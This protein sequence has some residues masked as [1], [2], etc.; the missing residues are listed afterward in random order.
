MIRMDVGEEI[1]GSL[2]QVCEKEGILLGQVSAIGAADHAEIGVYD[3]KEQQYHREELD[4]FMEIASLSGS[5]T[6]MNGRPSL[7][8]HATL[9]DRQ[10]GVHGGH[11]WRTERFPA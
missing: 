7:H 8:L 1:L 5:V 3:L 4:G 11:A 10:N 9:A 6:E 2:Q